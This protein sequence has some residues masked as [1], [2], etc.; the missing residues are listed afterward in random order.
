MESSFGIIFLAVVENR[1]QILSLKEILQHFI[2]HRKEVVVRRTRFDL[3]KAEARAHILEGLKI[4]L[5]N[6]DEVVTMIRRSKSPV[7]AKEQLLQRFPL[8]EIQAQEILNMRLQRLTGLEQEKIVEEYEAVMQDIA[9]FREILSSEQLVLNIIKDELT[10]IQTEFGDPRRTKIEEAG[11]ELTIED[12]IAEEDMVVTITNTGYIK[13]NPI[14]LY[15]S[16]RRGGKGK[17][18]MG[19]KEE[20]FVRLLFIASTHHTF[21]FPII[22]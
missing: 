19:T 6:L 12:M 21:M 17:T 5:D 15:Q 18:A 1:P 9:R 4:A 14:T 7:E 16:Q 11:V 2:L 13:R 8:T 20:D 3:A 10:Q 22:L